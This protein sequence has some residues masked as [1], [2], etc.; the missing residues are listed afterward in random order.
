MAEIVHVRHVGGMPVGRR[1]EPGIEGEPLQPALLAVVVD[2]CQEIKLLTV[3]GVSRRRRRQQAG[4]KR[5]GAQRRQQSQPEAVLSSSGDF[6]VRP[7]SGRKAE[8][9]CE[10]GNEFPP[11]FPSIFVSPGARGCFTE[12]SWWRIIRRRPRRPE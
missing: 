1:G 6:P 4:K 2:Q 7:H 5:Q 11:C 10:G 8:G 3:I 9:A 12:Q